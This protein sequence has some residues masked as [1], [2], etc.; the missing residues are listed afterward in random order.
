[1]EVKGYLFIAPLLLSDEM[2][3][4]DGG[5]S[6]RAG[7]VTGVVVAEG[8]AHKGESEAQ[9]QDSVPAHTSSRALGDTAPSFHRAR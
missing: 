3:A 7:L 2:S 9:L 6:G 4:E 8:K 1:M 5:G